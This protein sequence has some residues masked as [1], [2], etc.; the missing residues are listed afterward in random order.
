MHADVQWLGVWGVADPTRSEGSLD[1][2]LTPRPHPGLLR[3]FEMPPNVLVVPQSLEPKE[4]LHRLISRDLS[5]SRQLTP[6]QQGV[7]SEV[8]R[9]P[10]RGMDF[11]GLEGEIT[12]ITGQLFPGVFIARV[13]GTVALPTS[14]EDPKSLSSLAP[15]R[16]ARSIAAVDRAMRVMAM[17]AGGVR[18]EDLGSYRYNDDYFGIYVRVPFQPSAF[19]QVIGSWDADLVGLLVG[20]SASVLQAGV[21][22]RVMD[23]S[24]SL[25]EKSRVERLLL[26][27]QGALY[28]HP[29]G[30]Y[31]G[32]HPARFSR[33]ID[34][35]M[36]AQFAATYLQNRAFFERWPTYSRF[37]GEKLK[38]WIEKP[39]VVL[40]SSTS[41]RLT[42]ESLAA[43]LSLDERLDLWQGAN[44]LSLDEDLSR[45]F[46]QAPAEW[47]LIPNF[48]RAM[49]MDVEPR[50]VL[51][52][53]SD[54]ALREFILQDKEEASR[55]RAAGNFRAA[56][57]MAGAAAE[58][59]LLGIALR[60]DGDGAK[61]KL[62]KLAF[63][64]LIEACCPGY[65]NDPKNT[66]KVDWLIQPGTAAVLDI[67]ARP[68]RNFVHP[69][70]VLR[71]QRNATEA[72]ANAALSALDLLL[73][74]R[75]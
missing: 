39:M 57:V 73:V 12:S 72:T 2:Y 9:T 43:A 28:V 6:V 45:R 49:E 22:G 26:N 18:V 66:S 10:Y 19:E 44:G 38:V 27:K 67:A 4:G 46:N 34:L 50:D 63:Q 52:G 54:A 41:N 5:Q 3:Q 11:G 71:S 75:N 42:W 61:R 53:V 56:A 1:R 36:L 16:S 23:A 29:S 7:H 31:E 30:P 59:V 17:A 62:Q 14:I 33:T 20:S 13:K 21:I 37:I 65:A 70:L 47:W 55:C 35:V 69:G 24:A 32:P 64:E 25:N 68:W 8:R 15:L 48:H 74:D 60:R 40:Q 51:P 58:G